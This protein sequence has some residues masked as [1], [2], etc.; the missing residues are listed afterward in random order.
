MKRFHSLIPILTVIAILLV[1][2]SA[3]CDRRNPPPILPVIPPPP[4]A[5]NIRTLLN[6]NASP[7]TIYADNNITYSTI[8]V[9]VRDGEG[10]GVPNQLVQF[11]TQPIGRVLTNVVTDST[12]V[13]RS[14]FWDDGQSG[15]ATVTAIVR[16]WHESI[17][18]SLVSADTLMTTV[19]VKEIPEI[20]SVTLV[21]PTLAN[22]YPMNVSQAV[23]ISATAMNSLGNIVP[24]NT[25]I[26]FDCTM[27]RFVDS[28]GNDLGQNVVAQTFNG[29]ASVSYNSWTQATTAP[30]A[31]NA[32]VTASL[33]GKTS[34]RDILIR[35]GAPSNIELKSL[36]QVD[37][38]EIDST[39]SYVG[40]PNWIFMQATLKDAF[41]NACQT[42]PVKFT[43]DLGSFINTTQEVTVNTGSDGNA[44]VRF[45]P[46]LSAGAAT[47]KAFANG[48]TLNTQLIFTITS[49]QIHSL[50]FTQQEQISLNVANTGGT[51]SAILRVKLRDANNNLVDSPRDVYFKIMN[52]TPPA[53]SNLNNQPASEEVMVVSNGGEAQVS[54]NAG[55]E[56]GVLIIRARCQKDDGTWVYATKPNV[57]IHAGPP[58]YIRPFIGGF[59]TGT[60]MGGGLWRVIAG[61]EVKDQYNN[62]V[63]RGTSVWFQLAGDPICQ[64][65]ADGFVGNVS[66]NGD[67]LPGNAYTT[68][69]YSGDQTNEI[70][71]IQVTCGDGLGNYVVEV[72]DVP[73]PL[74]DPRF[75]IQA[76]P[77]ALNFG[78]NAPASKDAD[79]HCRLTDGQGLNVKGSMI[80]LTSTRGQL[81]RHPDYGIYYP[82]TG[83]DW[84]L[85]TGT[86]G[87]AVGR[88]RFYVVEI[89]LPDPVTLTPGTTDA[90]VT[91]RILGANVSGNTSITLFR[92]PQANPPF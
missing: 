33:G 75:E 34:S 10:F 67:S 73:L 82:E 45:T 70:I 30:G 38:T 64:I 3:S 32:V 17:A 72:K 14:L 79:L 90:L 92:Y 13:A 76:I 60:N 63:Q 12:G 83:V 24:N 35:P 69:T 18:D 57:V 11:K 52:S 62:P 44:R 71:W 21:F 84:K 31:T 4:S 8:S 39:S 58:H 27:G 48:D 88:I 6:M 87:E 61:A 68:V 42:K 28:A 19:V 55:T 40:S 59:N 15:T 43:T 77:Q 51:Q 80:T 56:S 9:E 1:S 86:N 16:K 22:P 23:Q 2:L 5:T 26:A 65:V 46:G 49:D 41:N 29:R 78:Q 81:V 91:G 54:V 47:I 37:G 89:P 20:E 85:V 74:N 36:V 53:G 7:D 25:L 66:A 50:D